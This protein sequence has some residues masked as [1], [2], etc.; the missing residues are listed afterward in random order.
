MFSYSSGFPV[1]DFDQLV[2]L[3]INVSC[4]ALF[5]IKQKISGFMEHTKVNIVLWKL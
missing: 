4:P 5:K 3:K 1:V 2:G